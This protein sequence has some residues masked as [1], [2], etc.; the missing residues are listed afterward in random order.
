M[1]VTLC[2]TGR[3]FEPEELRVMGLAYDAV[4]DHLKVSERMEKEIVAAM[5]IECARP[6]EDDLDLLCVAVLTM[7][8]RL[9]GETE[10]IG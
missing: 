10:S 2:P 1:T 3:V 9:M 7:Y 6:E 4:C 8:K 5:V